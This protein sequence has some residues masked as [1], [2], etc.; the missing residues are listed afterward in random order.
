MVTAPVF[1][2][3]V[4]DKTV[5]EAKTIMP[6]YLRLQHTIREAVTSGVL[7]ELE[8]LPGEREMAEMLGISR[9]TVRKALAAPSSRSIAAASNSHCRASPASPRICSCAG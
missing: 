7:H 1:G 2:S 6:L 4:F 8:A 5:F 3:A 9:V